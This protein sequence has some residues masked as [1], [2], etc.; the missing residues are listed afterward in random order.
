MS[1]GSSGGGGGNGVAKRLD[2]S[3]RELLDLSLRNPLLSFRPNRARGVTIVDELAREI[4]RVLVEEG[5]PMSF[6]AKPKPDTDEEQVFFGLTE[7]AE[8]DGEIAGESIDQPAPLTLRNALDEIVADD[9][10]RET[11]AARHTDNKL[12]TSHSAKRLATRLRNTRRTAVTSIEEQGVN[13][14][15]LALGMLEWYATDS[16]ET[17]RRAPLILVPVDIYRTGVGANYRLRYTQEEIGPNLSLEKKLT[18]DF[19]IEMPV[20]EHGE[21]DVE[22]Y[23]DRVSRA[24]A[25]EDGWSVD[26]TS[27]HL[28]FFSFTKLLLYLDL[29]VANWPENNKPTDHPLVQALLGG[30]GF[31]EADSSI[32]DGQ[33]LDDYLDVGV[34]HNVLDSDSSQTSAIIDA[35]EG[36]NLVVQG[37]PG[38]GKSQMICNLIADSIAQGKTVL[39]V[40]EKMAALEVV[41]RR[42]DKVH[43]GDACLELHSHAANSKAVGKELQRTMS[44]GKPKLG[45]HEID[46]KLLQQGR[47]RLNDYARAIS[48]PVHR[49]GHS[50]QVLIGKRALAKDALAEV[51]D[52]GP[53][54]SLSVAGAT[55]WSWEDFVVAREVVRQAQDLVADIG[56]P[57]RHTYWGSRRTVDL[58]GDEQTSLL[59]KLD[60]VSSALGEHQRNVESLGQAMGME[61]IPREQTR[62]RTE[63]LARSVRHF[64]SAPS[65]QGAVHRDEAWIRQRR[66]VKELVRDA[67]TLTSIRS[68]YDKMLIPEAWDTDLSSCRRILA[69]Y[70]NR[71]W[72]FFSADYRKAAAEFRGYCRDNPPRSQRDRVAVLDAVRE[73][74]DL[75]QAVS[76]LAPTLFPEVELHWRPRSYREL[77]DA[78]HWVLEVHQDIA[79][80][81]LDTVV[82]DL[83]DREGGSD[84]LKAAETTCAKSGQ[85]LDKA[86]A[87]LWELLEWDSTRYQPGAMP[88][89]CSFREIE[90][91]VRSAARRGRLN[92]IARFNRI[93]EQLA[94]RGLGS[95]ADVAASWSH[96][97][98]HLVVLYEHYFYSE[99]LN[100]AFR[101]RPVLAE[102]DGSDH[103]SIVERFRDLD[104][105][106]IETNRAL[107]AH[108]HWKGIPRG[109]GGGRLGILRREFQ[110]K[111]RHLPLRTLMKKAGEVILKIKPVFMMSPLSIAKYVSPGSVHFDLV[112]FDEAS[113]VRPVDALGAIMRGSQAI[114][115]GDNKQLPPTTFFDRMVS[116]DEETGSSTANLESVLGLF[117]AEGAPERMLRWHYRSRHESLIAVSNYEFYDSKLVVF[118][119]PDKGRESTGVVLRHHPE[120]HYEPGSILRQ[121]QR[122]PGLRTRYR[123]R[124]NNPGEARIVARAVMEHARRDSNLTL[125]VATFSLSQARQ[126]EDELEILRRRDSSCE[127]FFG[128]NQA[129]PFFVKNLENVQGDER[130]VILISVGYGKTE[131]G[132]LGM[133]FGPLT[134]EGGERRLN[135]LITRARRSCVVYSNFLAADLDLR[136]TK[137]RGLDALK[138]YL[139]YAQTGVLDVPKATGME[140]DSPFEQAVATALRARGHDIEH[141]VGSASYRVDLAVVHPERKG[142][143]ILAIECDG[144]IYHSANSARDRDRLRQE[145]LEGLGWRFH[146]IWSTDWF[147]NRDQEIERADEA[148]WRA[149]LLSDSIGGSPP[150]KPAR[151][152][153][154]QQL[155]RAKSMSVEA[156]HKAGPPYRLATLEPLAVATNLWH[157]PE[158]RLIDW[159]GQVVAVESPI[160]Y[161]EAA[162]RVAIAAGNGYA[163]RKA[164]AAVLA[165][166][167][168]GASDGK[169]HFRSPFLWRVGQEEASVRDRSALP[170]GHRLRQAE[171]IAPEEIRAALLEVVRDSYGI[172]DDQAA[173]N[174]SRLM[175]FRRL[176]PK[177]KLVIRTAL[178]QLIETGVLERQDEFLQLCK[179]R[180]RTL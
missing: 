49:S 68:K 55:S 61:L 7:A 23:F 59:R 58:L 163:N 171:M 175:G 124:R 69:A 46:K 172:T 178:G 75:R 36:R 127:E 57:Q 96:A 21:I 47:K 19:G 101:E 51:A 161:R 29:D 89:E 92:Q 6:L 136:R 176:G 44:L 24:V 140:P 144:A 91:W 168:Q 108:E 70:G 78:A 10:A 152:A 39:F 138:T 129:E 179:P 13:I 177:L 115:V 157:V 64:L 150:P 141:Q 143:Y 105:A 160:H 104:R 28:N 117:S 107:V 120:T 22:E 66:R 106:R 34:M 82:L 32:A 56:I 9:A 153:S 174:A 149:R 103:Q 110:K 4:Y 25:T 26:R 50:P 83:L 159:I 131:Q 118:P 1:T 80:G 67:L 41:K 135:V 42:L 76:E 87:G 8:G 113:Q 14:L 37:P 43:V 31:R 94:K 173:K 139:A 5:R 137:S 121:V 33:L 72:R 148:I 95:V 126:I 77:A 111:S 84:E 154:R 38:T 123:G 88:D 98:D 100:A 62:A 146:R 122:K 147:R 74:N 114:V 48:K 11:L 81:N 99:W 2:N 18:T 132:T 180:Q 119:S 116:E 151:C 30:D 167:R 63:L 60:K 12:Q 109:Y 128:R 45:D 165:A 93:A 79:R 35:R 15:Y 155:E 16:S 125:G 71:W 169:V 90:H 3:R 130:D 20:L 53:E 145:V 164:E 166:A 52:E 156:E 27:A 133:R 86:L 102:F 134:S 142:Q 17:C 85:V 65:L 73:A 162:R 158:D 40:A 97:A 54:P 170:N 112:I